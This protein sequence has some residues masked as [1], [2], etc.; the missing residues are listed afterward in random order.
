METIMIIEDDRRIREELS[1][2]LSAGYTALAVTEFTEEP[3][4]LL[5]E[6]HPDLDPYG[7]QYSRR[8]WSKSV[9]PDQKNIPGS[10]DFCNREDRGNG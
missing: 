1:L 7:Y 5:K 8:Q 9:R 4:K 3:I 6:N 2:L 10:G